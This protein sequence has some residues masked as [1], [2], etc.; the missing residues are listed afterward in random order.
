MFVSD[1]LDGLPSGTVELSVPVI[2]G[3][4]QIGAGGDVDVGRIRVFKDPGTVTV[5]QVDGTPMQVEIVLDKGQTARSAVFEESVEML[6]LKR[7]TDASGRAVWSAAEPVNVTH[8][9]RLKQFADIIG[10]FGAAKQDK[11]AK[12]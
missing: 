10:V 8:P 11:Q 12:R 4:I 9:D 5:A 7:C 6:R 3:V 1:K 2:G